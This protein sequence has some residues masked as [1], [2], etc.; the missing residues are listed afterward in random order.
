[1]ASPSRPRITEIRADAGILI[2]ISIWIGA[3]IVDLQEESESAS[4][5]GRP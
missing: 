5:T 2:A 3:G 1:V 4:L